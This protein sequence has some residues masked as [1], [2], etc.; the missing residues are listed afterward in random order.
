[1]LQRM[2]LLA[3]TNSAAAGSYDTDAQAY[4][5]AVEAA[6]GQALEAAVKDAINAFVVGCKTDGIWAAIK[7]SCILAGAR[8]LSGALVPLVGAAPTNNNFVSGDYNRK[9]GLKGN[10]GNK[11]LNTN[12][13]NTADPQNSRHIAVYVGAAGSTNGV[14]ISGGTVDG[15]GDSY[16]YHDTN[17]TINFRVNGSSHINPGGPTPLAIGFYGVSVTSSVNTARLN[18]TSYT[19]GYTPQAAASGSFILLNST[20]GYAHNCAITFYSIGE[21]LSLAQLNSRVFTLMSDL[22]AAIP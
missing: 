2:A 7:A 19:A 13:G 14:Y 18:N 5:T 10:S 16:I 1:M 20:T 6:D 3:A 9:T 17:G 22:A 4:I 15:G 21:S 11:S 12:R 8:T